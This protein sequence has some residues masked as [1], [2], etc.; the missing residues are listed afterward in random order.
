MARRWV[1]IMAIG[2]VLAGG[3]WKLEAAGIAFDLTK[4]KSVCVLAEIGIHTSDFG[5]TRET[6]GNHVY[7]W[8][9]GKLPKLQ[10]ERGTGTDPDSCVSGASILWASVNLMLDREGAGYFADVQLALHRETVWKSG[11]VGWGIA[12]TRAIMAKGSKA[13]FRK[14][15]NEVLDT[16][17]TDFAAEYYKAGN[18]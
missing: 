15:I 6:I 7:V 9:K 1:W 2:L 11:N 16:I 12:Y 3:G 10:L 14:H 17:L 5:L 13:I 4:L 18:P 8:L